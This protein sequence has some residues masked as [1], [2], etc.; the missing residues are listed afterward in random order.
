MAARDEDKTT[1]HTTEGILCDMKMP[2]VHI[3][4]RLRRYFQGHPIL[5]LTDQP[6]KQILK[7]PESS[8][9]FAKWEVELG[10]YEISFSPRH[11]IKGQ[12]LANFLLET[13]KKVDHSHNSKSNNRIW[14]LHTYGASSETG[15]GAGLVLTNPKGE[16]HTYALKFCFYAS[17]NEASL[18]GLRIATEMGIKQFACLCG[19]T[20]CSTTILV[21]VLK[22][23]S[24]NEKMLVATIEEEGPCWITPYIKYLQDRTLPA[25]AAEARWI[26]I[27]VPLYMLENGVL[28]RKSYNGPNLRCL[29]TQKAVDVVKEMHEGLC[30]HHSG[31]WTIVARI[32]RQGSVGNARFVVVAIDFFTKWVEAKVLTQIMGKNMKNFVWDDIV[33]RYRLPN[34][35]ANGQVEVIN[36]EI[37]AGIKARLG[38]SQTKW[39]DEVPYVFWAHQKMPKQS[40]SET[41]FSFVYGTEAVLPAEIR[42]PTHRVLAFDVENN[43]SVLRENLNLL[44][45]RRIMAAIRQADAKQRMTKYYNKRVKHVQFEEEDLVFRDNEASRQ[46]K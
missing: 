41:P 15:V 29:A 14:E 9:H 19:L 28:Y 39:V 31:Y 33:C 10:E 21:E 34:E 3:A 4:R 8:G 35:I 32:M 18:F 43:S 11:A 36:K 40:T 26:K 44:E 25:D 30:A 24:I 6:I 7:Q 37:V 22:D 27:S 20:Y 42:V 2:F 12:L 46:A 45:E 17:N 16:E 1:F 23:K 13:T 38:L 5:F